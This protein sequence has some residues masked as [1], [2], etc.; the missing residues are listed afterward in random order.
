[1]CVKII[2]R[3]VVAA[4]QLVPCW[5]NLVAGEKKKRLN[6]A[7][8]S[9]SLFLNFLLKYNRLGG[10]ARGKQGCFEGPQLLHF[11]DTPKPAASNHFNLDSGPR[12]QIIPSSDPPEPN[13][14]QGDCGASQ[15]DESTARAFHLHL[16][17]LMVFS[18]KSWR[19]RLM[20]T[21]NPPYPPP[22][23]STRR[24]PGWWCQSVSVVIQRQFNLWQQRTLKFNAAL[25]RTVFR[26]TQ[27]KVK[28]A[29]YTSF[30]D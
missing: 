30:C 18:Q 1:M 24:T 21:P 7:C 29:K 4:V 12:P 17:F 26:R 25:Q 16:V 5:N 28:A 14:V 15:M 19:M 11:T 13:N 2:S 6:W 3:S 23:A 22:S 10:E 9:F 27:T 8:L 20:P